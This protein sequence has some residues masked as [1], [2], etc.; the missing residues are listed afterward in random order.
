MIE[1]L[2]TGK[3]YIGQTMKQLSVRRNH[4]VRSSERCNY[5]FYRAIRKYGVENFVIEEIMWVEAPNKQSLKRKLDFLERHFIARYDTK[6][7]VITLPRVV[8]AY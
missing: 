2:V 5:K 3:W 4:H 8:M 7:R 1:C 6:R